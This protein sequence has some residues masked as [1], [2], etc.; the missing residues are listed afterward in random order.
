VSEEEIPVMSE[1]E[2]SDEDPLL[3]PFTDLD[4]RKVP[5]QGN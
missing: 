5:I 2:S 4:K 3:G 1:H